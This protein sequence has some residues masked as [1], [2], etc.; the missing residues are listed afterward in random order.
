MCVCVCIWQSSVRCIK[1]SNKSDHQSTLSRDSILQWHSVIWRAMVRVM[2]TVAER[3]TN[4][5]WTTQVRVCLQCKQALESCADLCVW[6]DTNGRE[7]PYE[8]KKVNSVTA[9]SGMR[10]RS[11]R[12]SLAQT[13]CHADAVDPCYGPGMCWL[14]R[15][16]G[17]RIQQAG[18][19]GS[20]SNLCEGCPVRISARTPTILNFSSVSSISPDTF[21]DSTRNCAKTLHFASFLIR[22]ALLVDI[23]CH[24]VWVTTE[25][26]LF[27]THF[28]NYLILLWFPMI[29]LSTWRP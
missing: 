11:G 21:R 19:F 12:F 3:A 27:C 9:L 8:W 10:F 2:I 5:D 25:G 1:E 20:A 24:I 18:S 23:R 16:M 15:L 22:Y 7:S 29:I 13:P 17:L 26:T 4:E 6:Y 14:Q 28:V